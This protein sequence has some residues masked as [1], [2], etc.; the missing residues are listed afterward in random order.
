M[1]NDE[2]Y[3]NATSSTTSSTGSNGTDNDRARAQ[4]WDIASTHPKDVF[5]NIIYPLSSSSKSNNTTI[6]NNN[7]DNQLCLQ[8]SSNI[9][10]LLF[11]LSAIS[12]S[13]MKQA[14]HNVASTLKPGG[15]LLLR[16]YGRYDE[17]QIKLGTSRNKRLGDNFYV[18]ND[19]T[20]CYYFSIEDMRQLFGS[21]D[22]DNCD[23]AGLEI[24]ELKYV[25][26]VYRNRA[27]EASRRRV[28]VQGRFRKPLL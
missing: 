8:S 11:V 6:T 17:A 1:Q 4:V 19:N 12:P 2:R 5:T 20:R 24:L 23:G 22:D 25:Q 21:S 27:N 3:I 13:K 18:K 7:N 14:A 16:D 10:L 26:R 9:S 28:W 15:I